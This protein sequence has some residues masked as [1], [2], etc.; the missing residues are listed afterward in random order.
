[1]ALPEKFDQCPLVRELVGRW[2]LPIF[3]GEEWIVETIEIEKVALLCPLESISLKS[4]NNYGKP[5]C[6]STV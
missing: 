6:S 4:E 5:F 3:L 1:M 2:H